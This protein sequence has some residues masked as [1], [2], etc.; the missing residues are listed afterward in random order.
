MNQNLMTINNSNIF[1]SYQHYVNVIQI[2]LQIIVKK[3]SD[4]VLCLSKGTNALHRL[5]Y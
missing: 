2:I 3:I 4:S 1:I 5:F